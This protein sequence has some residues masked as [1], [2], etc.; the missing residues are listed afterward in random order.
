MM[1]ELFS[2]HQ[3]VALSFSGGKESL[4]CLDL[5]RPWWD[6]L[7]VY[8]MNP[9]NPFPETVAQMERVRAMVPHFKEVAGRQ[10]EIIELDGWPSDLVP[11][12]YTSEGNAYF[13]KTPFKVQS[14]LQ[15]CIRAR[16]WPLYQAMQSDGVTCCIRGKRY[17][18]DDQTGLKSGFVTEHGIELV[19]PIFDWTTD[20]VFAYLDDHGIDRPPFYKHA[21]RFQD[22]MDCTAFWDYGIAGY[23]KAE[24]PVAFR[25]FERRMRFI[26]QV[27]T[28]QMSELE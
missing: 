4:V 10:R 19:F 23:L 16:M 14:R 1:D 18:D 22:C 15:C 2:R 7:T 25:E 21:H 12:R 27:V 13:G 17:D 26:K 3:K 24:H 9:G 28:E 6:R 20:E 8:W 11:D 5:L